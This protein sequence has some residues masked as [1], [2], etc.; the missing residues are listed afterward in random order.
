[1]R[2][3]GRS[4]DHSSLS[5]TVT[6]TFPWACPSPKKD[7]VENEVVAI[8]TPGEVL[9]RVVDDAVGADRPNQTQLGGAA[10]AGHLRTEGLGELHG[11]RADA[12]AGADEQDLL[13]GLDT[14]AS[15]SA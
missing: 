14:P 6:T 9:L 7:V 11:E 1:M 12:S 4:P 15:R 13:P 2:L 3:F 5:Q 10:H 8:L